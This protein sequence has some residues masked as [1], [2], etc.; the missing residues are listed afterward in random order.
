MANLRIDFSQPKISINGVTFDVLKSDRQILEDA[1]EIDRAFAGRNL[2]A[3][4]EASLE[5]SAAVA[6]F[7]ESILGAGAVEKVAG[8]VSADLGLSGVTG[9]SLALVSAA[10]RAYQE[11]FSFKYDD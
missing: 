10:N 5:Y 9:L 2:S 6:A 7:I 4:P 1:M 8:L 3:D 11:A